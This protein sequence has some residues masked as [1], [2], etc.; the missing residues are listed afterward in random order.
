[1]RFVQTFLLRIYV[2]PQFPSR[3]CGELRP[4]EKREI[5]P[6]KNETSL[7]ELLQQLSISS[8]KSDQSGSIESLPN[9]E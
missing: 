7:M 4:I 8:D 3:L 6:F 2:D 5:Y 9:R 1:M